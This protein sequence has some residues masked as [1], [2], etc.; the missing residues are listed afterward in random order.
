VTIVN[1]LRSK[2]AG[3]G[4]PRRQV[5]RALDRYAGITEVHVV[6][7]DRA[8]LDAALAAGRVLAEAAPS[9][10][11]RLAIRELARGI[12]G[13]PG[14]SPGRRRARRARR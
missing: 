13:D 10:P 6:P 8:G 1:R 4:D 11:A 3:P 5:S 9:S 14:P 12:V 7:E 2:V